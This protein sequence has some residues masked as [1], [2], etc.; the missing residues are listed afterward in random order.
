LTVVLLVALT[1]VLG[2]DAA[3]PEPFYFEKLPDG[4]CTDIFMIQASDPFTALNGL[5]I[6]YLGPV[7]KI[8]P[9]RLFVS[10]NV[11]IEVDEN[12]S[13]SGHFVFNGRTMEGM[14]T[15]GHGTGDLEGFHAVGKMTN[16]SG[17]VFALEGTYHFAPYE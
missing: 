2:V 13:I 3:K 10:S 14:F 7:V 8:P 5:C 9:E 4:G 17:M 12:T 1:L 16:P 6:D 11:L 15:L